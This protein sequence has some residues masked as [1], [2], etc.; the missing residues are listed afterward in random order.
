VRSFEASNQMLQRAE[1]VIPL[2]SQTFSKSRTQYPQGVSPLFLE[3][4][5][6]SHVWDVDGNEYIDFVSALAAVT[7]GYCD[8][9]VDAAVRGQIDSGVILSLPH[10]LETEVAERICAMVPSAEMVRFGKNGSD[11]TAGAVRLARAF[12]GRDHV[13]VCGYHG[14]QD[15]YIGSTLRNLGVPEATQ[16]LTHSFAYGDL[17]AL[18]ALFADHPGAIAAVIMEPLSI[19]GLAPAYLRS[20]Q[21]LVEREGALLIF[22]EMITGFRVA[23]GG[24]QQL[25]GITP[26]LSC[27]GKG[28]ANGYPL[29]AVAGRR[30][31]MKLMDEIFF[32]FTFGGDTLSLVAART[33]LDKIQAEPIL[34]R[35]AEM[36]NVLMTELRSLI[37]QYELGSIFAVKGY[38]SWNFLTITGTEAVDVFEIRTLLMQ[39]LHQ[40]GI[41]CLGAHNMSYAHGAAE[42]DA[43][44]AAYTRVM[45]MIGAAVAK[46]NARD[47]LRCPPL[48][49][50]F[51]VR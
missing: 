19:D 42:I 33:V 8:P 25:L 21:E 37:T 20:V 23:K 45:P 38:P 48:A 27:F 51:R 12:T 10:R 40:A 46:G 36:G 30:D 35:I 1:R 13:A 47:L 24:A 16:G 49:P 2:G 4:G 18:E 41:L 14:W 43:L 5:K 26:D 28:L 6:G 22:D 44:I 7:L 34:E 11:A 3:R 50:L 29:A 31:V 32:S 9:D 39:E 17:A 15:W